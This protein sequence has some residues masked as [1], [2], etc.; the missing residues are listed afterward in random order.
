MGDR[1]S[2]G[3]RHVVDNRLHTIG[4]RAG[5][6]LV[7]ISAGGY[8]ATLIAL[9]NPS[10]YSVVESWSGYFHATNPT[11]TVA[12][13]LGSP[14][15]DDWANAHK[16]IPIVSRFLSGYRTP[17]YFAFYV[18]SNDALFRSENEEFYAELKHAGI[19]RVTF[20]LYDGDHNWS[21]WGVH[22]AAWIGK[23]L[24]RSQTR[25]DL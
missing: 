24:D 9:H 16:L 7:G 21:L 17:T 11:G 1:D 10:V 5:R 19:R 2:E 13:E 25:L 4:S 23:G 12:L 20:R 14:E 22:A 8:G 15:A 6:L 3:A 18:G